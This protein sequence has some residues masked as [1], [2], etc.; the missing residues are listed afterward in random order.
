MPDKSRPP[1][2]N[3]P[4]GPEQKRRRK[5]WSCH[6]CRRKKLQCDRTLPACGR[7]TKA[8]KPE[9]C[10]YIDDVDE[11]A[12]AGAAPTDIHHGT[13]HGRFS[14]H[15]QT[16]TPTENGVASN[17]LEDFA[18]RIR[19][20]E[21]ALPYE[22]FGAVQS[23]NSSRLLPTPGSAVTGIEPR[24][25]GLERTLFLGRSFRTKFNGSTHAGLLIGHIPGFSEFTTETFERFPAMNRIRQ[26]MHKL[27]NLT[28][29]ARVNPRPTIDGQ[30][31]A[32]LPP[33]H[34][35]NRLVRVFMDSF[36]YIYHVLHLPSFQKEYD[37]LWLDTGDDN[38]QFVV[39]VILIIAVAL[40]LT[41][42]AAAYSARQEATTI[43]RSC[44]HWLQTNFLKY[45]SIH[46]FQIS[47]LLLF[48]RQLNARRYK[49]T[50]ANSGEV[51]RNFMCAG[52]HQDPDNLKEEMS[53]LDKEMRRRIWAAAAEFELQASFEQGMPAIPWPE[54]SDILP[55]E[56]IPDDDLCHVLDS[57]PVQELTSSSYLAVAGNSILLRH[58]LNAL[59][60]NVRLD[61][62]F[63][64]TKTFTERIETSLEALPLWT[65]P[66]SETPQALLSI[67]LRQY[68]LALHE[69][70]ARRAASPAERRFSKMILLDTAVKM[71]QSHKALLE[72]G[73]SALKLLCGD[74]IRAALSICYVYIT[75]D[76]QSELM[77]TRAAEQYAA[78]AID[79]A[80]TMLK[81][82]VVRLNGDQRHLWTAI[83]AKTI[84]KLN[85]EP[86]KRDDFMQEA[87]DEYILVFDEIKGGLQEL[88]KISAET[89]GV[90]DEPCEN[91][92]NSQ[93]Q[94]LPE[95]EVHE[96]LLLAPPNLEAW[97]FEDWAF[98]DYSM[99]FTDFPSLPT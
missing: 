20:L 88:L 10:I 27:E 79:D 68:Q 22:T 37:K 2:P 70:Q 55:P 92:D 13:L 96:R 31:R 98:G 21:A 29:L 1:S 40:C 94:G 28:N 26:H 62:S 64:E 51:L 19:Q 46:D 77:L 65:G 69:R 84:M 86:N 89:P 81:Q 33:R 61:M 15:A 95:A 44:E 45:S 67:N 18:K 63:D 83:A 3:A 75:L 56:N 16:A 66:R 6:E 85:N 23:S 32:L 38:Q 34:E 24:Q 90:V 71:I 60:N 72:S 74:H 54:Q 7:C 91:G 97:S 49:Q 48:A 76:P 59:L 82:K 35:A 57:R 25:K 14:H 50:W 39:V 73:N 11:A 80:V 99:N 17:S 43:I 4:T 87:A 8:G 9:A 5:I 30:L 93:E 41:S 36:D 53:A 42:N 12:V 78:Q 58:K 52:L 47:F